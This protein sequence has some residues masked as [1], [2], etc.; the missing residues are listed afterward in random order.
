MRGFGM[1]Y[2]SASLV[3]RALQEIGRDPNIKPPFS[4]EELA[5]LNHP[6]EPGNPAPYWQRIRGSVPYGPGASGPYSWQN[7]PNQWALSPE[8]TEILNLNRDIIRHVPVFADINWNDPRIRLPDSYMA[9]QPVPE[10]PQP[11]APTTAGPEP[12]PVVPPADSEPA[13]TTSQAA[14]SAPVTGGGGPIYYG[15]PMDTPADE[16]SQPVQVQKAGLFSNLTGSLP[17][18]LGLSAL[19]FII[20]GRPKLPGPAPRRRRRR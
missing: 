1:G 7:D 16:Y 12:A 20:L 5:W 3:R 14:P 18:L 11:V 8:S 6:G 9:I 15:Q 4:D 13:F 19:G 17:L 10:L 2:V